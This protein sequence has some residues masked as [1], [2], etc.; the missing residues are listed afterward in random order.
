MKTSLKMDL[1]GD[2]EHVV[3]EKYDVYTF[4]NLLEYYTGDD[5]MALINMGG[6]A[7]T[8]VFNTYILDSIVMLLDTPLG[9]GWFT[10]VM[11][12]IL[13]DGYMHGRPLPHIYEMVGDM[14]HVPMCFLPEMISDSKLRNGKL[15]LNKRDFVRGI[16]RRIKRNIKD[17]FDDWFGSDI[18]F[19]HT[20]KHDDIL[21]WLREG[22]CKNSLQQVLCMK[23]PKPSLKEITRDMDVGDYFRFAPPCIKQINKDIVSNDVRHSAYF[24][25][26]VTLSQCGV[27]IEDAHMYLNTCSRHEKN[28]KRG[29]KG[30]FDRG[31]TGLG[32]RWF[33]DRGI[34][35]IGGRTCGVK[36][37]SDVIINKIR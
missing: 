7:S 20:G 2:H 14:Y 28:G 21:I 18:I 31:Y 6:T 5:E 34:C 25:M 29:L 36:R 17:A 22:I 8:F 26:T 11:G 9:Q 24:G 16:V 33:K 19:G 23:K 4:V 13:F 35:P 15:I 3:P 30:T 32:C 12:F 10:T 27:D 37:P 1:F